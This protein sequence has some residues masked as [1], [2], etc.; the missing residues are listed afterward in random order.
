[1][2]SNKKYIVMIDDCAAGTV[3][4]LYI[5]EFIEPSRMIGARVTIE[6]NDEDGKLIT[7]RGRMIEIL[8]GWNV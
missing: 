3:G 6:L 7:K 1:M 2:I 8:E 5:P 4:A